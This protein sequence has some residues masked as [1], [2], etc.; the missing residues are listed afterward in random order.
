MTKVHHTVYKPRYE[1]YILDLVTDYNGDELPTREAKI[2]QLFKRFYSEY[3]YLVPLHGKQPS[4]AQWLQGL[5][6]DIEYYSQDIVE[7]AI[8]FGS[9]DANPSAKL[10]AKVIENYW[11]FMANIILGMEGQYLSIMSAKIEKVQS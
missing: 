10:E 11:K 2:E 6:L 9:I 4:M 5:A 1:A 3:G 8:R 7:L